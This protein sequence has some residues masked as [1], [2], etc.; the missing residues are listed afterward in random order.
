MKL[1]IW[2]RIELYCFGIFILGILTSSAFK[3]IDYGFINFLLNSEVIFLY[4]I[5]VISIVGVQISLSLILFLLLTR[6]IIDY[7]K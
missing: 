1:K 2:D 4:K 7:K 3:V 6:K 5:L